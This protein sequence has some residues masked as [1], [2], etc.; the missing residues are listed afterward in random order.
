MRARSP[1]A[2]C[3][4]GPRR[5][6]R[7]AAAGCRARS[8]ARKRRE[9]P[10][11]S[12]RCCPPS[13]PTTNGSRARSRPAPRLR[14]GGVDRNALPDQAASVPVKAAAARSSGRERDD[15]RDENRPRGAPR[16][17]RRGEQADT[18]ASEGSVLVAERCVRLAP[19]PGPTAE[20]ARDPESSGQ[21]G[22]ATWPAAARRCSWP[23]CRSSPKQSCTQDRSRGRRQRPICSYLRR[24]GDRGDGIAR[25][26]YGGALAVEDLSFTVRPSRVTGFAGPNGAG[27]STT[28]R[29][30]LGLDAPDAGDA[31]GRSRVRHATTPAARDRRAA[32]RRSLHP[33]HR[34]RPP[35]VAGAQ[36]RHQPRRVD[37]VHRPGRPRG[38]A[39][40]RI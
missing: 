33:G 38:A 1:I 30:L 17:R 29:L 34:T 20:Q 39:R 18:T 23:H 16:E 7:S 28:M 32:R 40:R 24:Y 37:A 25:S 31:G 22:C 15:E 14:R 19:P 13:P 35:A 3:S 5:A 11:P 12:G 9:T 6:R 26:W 4:S 21:V 10:R 36:Q 2:A 8:R 27:K